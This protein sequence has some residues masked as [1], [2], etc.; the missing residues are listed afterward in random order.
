MTAS[1]IPLTILLPTNISAKAR[2]DVPPFNIIIGTQSGYEFN[3]GD[4]ISDENLL[5]TG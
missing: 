4:D 2:Q 3:F 1:K 5:I